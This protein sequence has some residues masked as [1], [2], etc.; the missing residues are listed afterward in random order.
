MMAPPLLVGAAFL[1]WGYAGNSLVLGVAL[2]AA[3]EIARAVGPRETALAKREPLVIQLTLA[4]TIVLFVATAVTQ[5]F[6]GAIYLALRGLPV[7][8][9]PVAILQVLARERRLASGLDVTHGLGAAALVGAAATDPN[10]A[11]FYAAAATIV[12]VA[13]FARAPRRTPALAML[14]VAAALGFAIHTGL[15]ALQSRVEDWSTDLLQEF[16]SAGADPFRERTRIGELGRVKLS[17]R[18]ALRLIPEGRRPEQVLLREA[19]FDAYV[20]GEWHATERAFAPNALTSG[21]WM[22][23]AQP[24]AQ[25]LMIRRA[26]PRHEGVLALPAGTTRIAAIADVSLGLLP[27]GTVR[28]VGL[29]SFTVMRIQY[30]PSGDFA[31][32]PS[33][34]DLEVPEAL[35]APLDQ[36]LAEAR[37]PRGRPQ[38]TEAGIRRFFSEHYGYTLVLSDGR[39]GTRTLRDFLLTD[40]KG[41][42]EYFATAT[43]LLLRAAGVPARY[44]VG[45]SAQ[46]YS[47][48]ERAFIVRDRHA[49]AWASAW[50]DGRWIE[51]DNTPSRWADFE[52]QENR[53]W[54]GPVLDAFSWMIDAVRRNVIEA[55]WNVGSIVGAVLA[56]GAVVA[57][58][59]WLRRR[60]WRRKPA[61]APAHPATVAW[62]RIEANLALRGLARNAGETPRDYARRL[63]ARSG[64]CSGLADLA[65]AY[66][67][68]RFDPASE[69]G[70]G[71]RLAGDVERWLARATAPR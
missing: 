59:A 2:A 60:P 29:P 52:E 47:A 13:I 50:I 25:A 55:S 28:A 32:A 58:L 37:V 70:A 44:A 36:V 43:T 48:L 35:R 6:P 40:R 31:G 34:A 42:C 46:E 18:I 71:E 30:E 61:A 20:G 57:L 39:G 51:V 22:L 17:D 65:R 1:A 21:T 41:H 15:S 54:Y 3:F 26:T 38:D 69:A 62:R 14:A 27:T 63:E 68:A 23:S 24:G 33:S 45:Y 5:A 49:H 66:Y 67:A 9:L 53:A 19:A 12:S 56:L 11:W 64:D 7:V 8:L 10:A 16:F 4:A